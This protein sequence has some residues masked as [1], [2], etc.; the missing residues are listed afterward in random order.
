MGE[1]EPVFFWAAFIRDTICHLPQLTT[2]E[3]AAAQTIRP[4]ELLVPRRSLGSH[5]WSCTRK[6]PTFP[7]RPSRSPDFLQRPLTPAF[8]HVGTSSQGSFC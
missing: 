2:H 7:S 5:A 4:S 1:A 6:R 3:E 8:V